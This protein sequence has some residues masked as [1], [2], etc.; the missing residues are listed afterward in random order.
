M[1][2]AL[3][4][5]LLAGCGG[6]ADTTSSGASASSE[7]SIADTHVHAIERAGPDGGVLLATHDGLWV[8]EGDELS[9][10]GPQID[11]MGFGVVDATT[12]RASGHPGPGVDLAEPVGLIESRDAGQTWSALSRAGESDFHLLEANDMITVGLDGALRSSADGQEWQEADAPDGLLDLALAP[13]GRTLLATTEDGLLVSQD[14]GATWNP[15]PSVPPLVLLDWADTNTVVGISN[16]GGVHISTDG[17]ATWEERDQLNSAI[18]TM[19][20]GRTP[21]GDIELLIAEEAAFRAV[22]IP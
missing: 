13:S 1:S 6:T 4:S 17:G 20:A 16:D 2:A 12:Y 5:V 15:V 14:E 19:S 3:G 10:V 22:T 8:A 18:Q 9:Q 21:E 11:L 7:L